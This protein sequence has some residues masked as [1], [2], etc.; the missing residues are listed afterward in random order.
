[1]QFGIS[2]LDA[3]GDVKAIRQAVIESS[4]EDVPPEMHHVHK[5]SCASRDCTMTDGSAL[6][7]S[8]FIRC[9]GSDGAA[10]G[11]DETVP[12]RI[13]KSSMADHVICIEI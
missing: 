7:R 13:H 5:V 11:Y 9:L 3:G 4:Y 10:T 12:H 2:C 1:M 6:L 8:P